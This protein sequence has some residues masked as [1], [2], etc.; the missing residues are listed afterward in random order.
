MDVEKGRF[1][2]AIFIDDT[3][4]PSSILGTFRKG[5]NDQHG[6]HFDELEQATLAEFELP[7]L[8]RDVPTIPAG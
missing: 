8:C 1:E 6:L 7:D 3:L 2:N 4:Y 5:N